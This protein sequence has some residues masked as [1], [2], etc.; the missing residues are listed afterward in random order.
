MV[1]TFNIQNK[2]SIHHTAYR[3]QNIYYTT[4]QIINTTNK[5]SSSFFMAVYPVPSKIKIFYRCAA[6]VYSTTGST[7]GTVH[8]RLFSSPLIT[9]PL[10]PE[11]P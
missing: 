1:T 8:G 2:P 4:K 11:P 9:R 7:G 6:A 10:A 3:V 5:Q